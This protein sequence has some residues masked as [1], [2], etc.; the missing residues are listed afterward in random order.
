MPLPPDPLPAQEAIFK[1]INRNPRSVFYL[2]ETTNNQKIEGNQVQLF[3]SA[4]NDISPNVNLHG[5]KRT[6]ESA[7]FLVFLETSDTP[8]ELSKDQLL[9]SLRKALKRREWEDRVIQRIR[10]ALF[11]NT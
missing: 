5:E 4:W 10:H 11:V 1:H 8:S 3:T 9:D 2:S 6:T 7:V